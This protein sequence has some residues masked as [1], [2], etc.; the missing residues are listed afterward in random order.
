MRIRWIATAAALLCATSTQ[1]DVVYNWRHESGFVNDLHGPRVITGRLEIDESAWFAGV[2]NYRHPGY[3]FGMP[4]SDQPGPV[5][6]FEL[7]LLPTGVRD[8]LPTY[9]IAD[10]TINLTFAPNGDLSGNIVANDTF[11]HVYMSGEGRNWSI[12]DHNRDSWAGCGTGSIT[13]PV[14]QSCTGATGR[15]VLDQATRP[16]GRPGSVPL[17]GT[18]PLMAL[19]AFGVASALRRN[20]YQGINR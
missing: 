20:V 11:A 3:W 13:S 14:M 10:V 8:G 1:A 12:A 5:R 19:A 2:V 7:S 4:P 6:T 15:W 9:R 17:P 18:L 16:G